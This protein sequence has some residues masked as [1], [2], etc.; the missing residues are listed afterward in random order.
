[1]KANNKINKKKKKNSFKDYF[2][3][4]PHNHQVLVN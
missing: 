2:F 4:N 3:H 1:M